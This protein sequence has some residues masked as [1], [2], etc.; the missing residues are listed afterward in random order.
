MGGGSNPPLQEGQ[1]LPPPL[2]EWWGRVRECDYQCTLYCIFIIYYEF[3]LR[4]IPWKNLIFLS[5]SIF[6]Y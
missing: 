3:F 1:V 6:L 2:F 4:V 5:V